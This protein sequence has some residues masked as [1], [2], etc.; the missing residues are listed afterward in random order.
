LIV[1]LG[2]TSFP[3]ESEIAP[4]PHSKEALMRPPLHGF[5]ACIM[6]CGLAAGTLAPFDT[7]SA[8]SDVVLYAFQD[9]GDGG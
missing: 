7:A 1:A 2:S 3:F 5:N 9:G 4:A 6:I 8:K